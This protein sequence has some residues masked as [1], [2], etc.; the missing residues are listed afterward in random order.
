DGVQRQPAARDLDAR[1]RRDGRVRRTLRGV[2]V[3]DGGDQRPH[4]TERLRV[5]LATRFHAPGRPV[6]EPLGPL[7]DGGV[8]ALPHIRDDLRDL[9]DA[10][11]VTT[12]PRTKVDSFA[13]AF[14]LGLVSHGI[15]L[16]TGTTRIDEAPAAFNGGSRSQMS[17][18]ATAAWTAIWPGSASGSTDGAPIP[19]S[20]SRIGRRAS[21][22]RVVVQQ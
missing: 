5:E 8:A 16:S 13:V 9:G 17:S 12:S 15:S 14:V 2:D 1:N 21:Y 22:G 20:S 4:R 7:A 19:G 3:L 6:A 18:A 10:G 11:G